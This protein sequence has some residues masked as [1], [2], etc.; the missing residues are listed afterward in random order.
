MPIAGQSTR[1]DARR[2]RDTVITAA[3]DLL[4]ENPNASMQEVAAA[5]G[6]GRTTVYRHFPSR[7][8]LL[9]SLFERV[10]E[11]AQRISASIIAGTAEPS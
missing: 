3:I 11:E 1:S 10:V 4:G 6:L 7:E 9:V 8:T 2:N 5:S